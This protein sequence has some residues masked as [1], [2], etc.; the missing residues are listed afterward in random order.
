MK[1]NGYEKSLMVN[2]WWAFFLIFVVFNVM[3][4]GLGL[5]GGLYFCI[6][7]NGSG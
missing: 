1:I 6:V 2:Y 4:L 7:G 3:G 5:Y